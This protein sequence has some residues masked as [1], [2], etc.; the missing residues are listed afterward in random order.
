MYN[1]MKF[2]I[3]ILIIYLSFI[4]HN[5]KKLQFHYYSAMIWKFKRLRNEL[6]MKF[7]NNFDSRKK[8]LYS[9]TDFSKSAFHSNEIKSLGYIWFLSFNDLQLCRFLSFSKN[10]RLFSIVCNGL[11][12]FHLTD[13]L[14]KYFMLWNIHI[15]YSNFYQNHISSCIYNQYLC[16]S[17]FLILL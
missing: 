14:D 6:L 1:L 9:T 12:F 15:S 7:K 17:K 16:T 13:D 8:N 11:I 10:L 5:F 2:F 3:K 4:I